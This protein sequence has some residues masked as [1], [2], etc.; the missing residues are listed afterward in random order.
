MAGDMDDPQCILKR[1]KSR[2][3]DDPGDMI[4][5]NQVDSVVYFGNKSELRTSLDKS[6]DEVVSIRNYTRQFQPS[7]VRNTS[8]YRIT[9]DIPGTDD[10]AL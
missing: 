8:S 6:Q 1:M 5:G 7:S 9:N 10:R 2:G 4:D 3:C